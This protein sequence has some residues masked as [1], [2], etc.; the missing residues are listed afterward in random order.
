MLFEPPCLLYWSSFEP[1]TLL[2]W[3]PYSNPNVSSH[4]PHFTAA[5]GFISTPPI[6]GL[7][8]CTKH[9]SAGQQLNSQPPDDESYCHA[10][11]SL[12]QHYWLQ[13]LF[14]W[15]FLCRLLLPL[16]VAATKL[17]I[18][19]MLYVQFLGSCWWAG[20]PP[21]TCRALTAIKNIVLCCMLLV[22]IS[23]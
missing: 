20:R 18:Y 3:V 9:S 14:H 11:H 7:L 16:A 12:K 23:I 2:E 5:A 17:N 13:S 15:K 6:T 19:Q 1:Y 10:K 22:I 4:V 8:L 21:E